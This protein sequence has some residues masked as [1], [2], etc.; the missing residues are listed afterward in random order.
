MTDAPLTVREFRAR[1]IRFCPSCGCDTLPL[2]SGLCGFCDTRLTGDTS[3]LDAPPLRSGWCR[4]P[5]CNVEFQVGK[6]PGGSGREFCC[7]KHQQTYW[8]HHTAAGMAY[9]DSANERRRVRHRRRS[10][11]LNAEGLSARGNQVG[12]CP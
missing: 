9:R 8:E 12:P 4:L 11:E 2:D 7:K 3:P 6:G 1:Y 5:G 10:A